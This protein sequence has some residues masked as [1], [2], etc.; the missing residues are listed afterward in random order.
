[1]KKVLT[2]LGLIVLT[3]L[4]TSCSSGYEFDERFVGNWETGTIIVRFYENGRGEMSHRDGTGGDTFEWRTENERI[5]ISVDDDDFT[6][7]SA[8]EFNENNTVLT[9]INEELNATT[10]YTRVP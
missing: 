7:N 5:I 10:T 9:V 4:I 1:M 6:S 2:I 8:F 3:S